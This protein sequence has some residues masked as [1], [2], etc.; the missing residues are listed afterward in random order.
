V[1]SLTKDWVNQACREIAELRLT[2]SSIVIARP[3]DPVRRGFP[4]KRGRL[5]NTG[6]P[7]QA[8]DD[9]GGLFENGI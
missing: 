4:V 3:D 7:G 5:W 8:G 2:A 1:E 6:S 9:G